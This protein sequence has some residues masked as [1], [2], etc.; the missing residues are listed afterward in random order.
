M[1]VLSRTVGQSICIGD[2]IK[3]QVL[4]VVGSG[5]VRLGVTAPSDIVVDREEITYEK[6]RKSMEINE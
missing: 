1:L 6:N 3:V 5:R 4:S 2:N